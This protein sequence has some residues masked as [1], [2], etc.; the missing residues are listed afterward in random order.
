MLLL[1]NLDMNLNQIFNAL[2]QKL[3]TDPGSPV[4]GQFWYNTT[5][6]Q[7][8][9]YNGTITV[10]V[11][12]SDTAN[13]ASTNVLRDVSGN[14][15]VNKVTVATTT[16]TAS[17]ELASKGYVDSI[18]AGLQWKASVRVATTA[19]IT[20]TGTQTIDGVAVVAGDRI[21]VKNQTVG[22]QNGIYVV[23][24]GAWARSTDAAT[25]PQ[26]GDGAAVFIDEGTTLQSTGWVQ[27]TNNPVVIG[28]TTL[29][30]SQ[31]N[32]GQI[33]T[34]GNGLGLTGN[35][36]SVTS[37]NTGRIAVSGAGVDLASGIVTPG[38]YSTVTVDTYGRVTAGS[39]LS[40]ISGIIS[41]TA[42]NTYTGRTI[43]GTTSLITVTNGD[44]IA[45]NPTITVGANV[46]TVGGATPVAI[47]DG[48]T[49]ATTAIQ[50][51][52]NLGTA[53][54]YSV[55]LGD[56]ASVSYTITHNLNTKDV[57]VALRDNITPFAMVQTDW[58]ATTVNTITVIFSVAPTT[59]KY[60][61][62]VSG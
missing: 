42:A 62:I 46:Y 9:Y 37:V 47:T 59:N 31:F 28:T 11:Y 14:I 45:G 54:K 61:V 58:Q 43:I 19:N 16:P 1:N 57:I 56:G 39:E 27:T 29:V 32:G 51:R 41:R 6:H 12:T 23:S 33:Y 7:L 24:V 48:G 36:F 30:F 34:A 50:A 5:T 38:T 44:G 20:L 49:G 53:G 25:D 60:R 55:D 40:S 17:N 21:L 10:I 4:E 18:A 35:A 22:S 8:K 52:I 15:S 26:L 13:T 2:A 3:G